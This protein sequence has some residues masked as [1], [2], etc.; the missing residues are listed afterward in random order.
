MNVQRWASRLY[1]EKKSQ[2]SKGTL[3]TF[4][5]LLFFSC[6]RLRRNFQ[7]R[8]LLSHGR[9]LIESSPPGLLPPRQW[10]CS[11]VPTGLRN[12]NWSMQSDS[13][14]NAEVT[15]STLTMLLLVYIAI[16]RRYDV[17]CD[18][19]PKYIER[20]T[21]SRH[22]NLITPL[23][24]PLNGN[25]GLWNL[26]AI[27]TDTN[28]WIFSVTSCPSQLCDLHWRYRSQFKFCVTLPYH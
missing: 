11:L 8:P 14:S 6:L 22:T 1:K 17:I 21:F 27:I 15:I 4:R 23:T 7:H 19:F 25:S 2:H 12:G 16:L 13:M 24:K 9:W 20:M 18:I 3:L 5:I 28:C 26:M 10:K